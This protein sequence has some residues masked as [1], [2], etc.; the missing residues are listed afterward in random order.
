MTKYG[1]KTIVI[2]GIR[3]ASLKEARRWGDLKLLEKAGQIRRLQLQVPFEIAINGKKCFSYIADFVYFDGE[4]RVVEDVKG[5]RTPVYR[6]KKKCV[7]AAYNIQIRE[8]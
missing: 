2:D 8:V 5:F 4:A 1:A 6:L 7:E 3:F